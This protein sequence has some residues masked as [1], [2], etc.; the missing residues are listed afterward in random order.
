MPF[1]PRLRQEAMK[2]L[3][4][5]RESGFLISDLARYFELSEEATRKVIEA[6]GVGLR[7]W[8]Y[9]T[10]RICYGSLSP[11]EAKRVIHFY[12]LRPGMRL[13]L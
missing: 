10:G 4:A 5:P 13:A 7:I 8:A 12:R 3:E 11:D 6:A 2:R 1:L 9:D